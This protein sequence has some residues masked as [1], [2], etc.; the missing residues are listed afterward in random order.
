MTGDADHD[1]PAPSS[2]GEPR[3]RDEPVEQAELFGPLAVSRHVKDDGR[4]LILYTHRRDDDENRGD[5]EED[6]AQGAA[7]GRR[8]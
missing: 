3:E 2:S 5:Q 1:K 6:R 8:S 7:A 4:A